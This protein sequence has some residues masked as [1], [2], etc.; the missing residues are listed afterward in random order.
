MTS[1]MNG[2]Y[3]RLVNFQSYV[4]FWVHYLAYQ[5]L[6]SI[7]KLGVRYYRDLRFFMLEYASV[8]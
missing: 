1:S 7:A 6:T 4:F 2:N 8:S 5:Q 3:E